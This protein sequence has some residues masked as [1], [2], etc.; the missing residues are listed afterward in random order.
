MIILGNLFSG[1]VDTDTNAYL[2]MNILVRYEMSKF[3]GDLVVLAK[4]KVW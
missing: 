3:D 4:A 1:F 2:Y